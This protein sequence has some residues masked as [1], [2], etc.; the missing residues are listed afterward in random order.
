MIIKCIDQ[1]PTS[2]NDGDA[3]SQL[4]TQALKSSNWMPWHL[5]CCEAKYIAK[6]ASVPGAA[7]EL[8][9]EI[10]AQRKIARRSKGRS[11]WLRI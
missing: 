3:S 9:A 6:Y 1:K 2:T 10:E 11:G 5:R 7:K 8:A 4:A